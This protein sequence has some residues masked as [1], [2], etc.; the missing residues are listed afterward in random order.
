MPERS[1]VLKLP[2]EVKSWL[3]K[4]LIDGNFS[5]YEALSEA[6]KEKGYSISKSSIHRYGKEFEENLAAIKL[7]TEQAKAIV[8]S[9]EDDAGNMN[10]AL[11]RLVQQ[12]AFQVLTKLE[13]DDVKSLTSL[14]Q[15]AGNIAK[16]SVAVKKYASDVKARI[17]AKLAELE[18]K[19]ADRKNGLDA[20]TLR[21]IR[22][23]IYGIMA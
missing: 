7:A 22:E 13:T 12:K 3:D 2:A 9:S 11:L 5:G 6:L 4:A 1:L 23:E 17:S 20:D 14:G 15:M 16:S 10:E 21:K 18:E 19:S 8:E